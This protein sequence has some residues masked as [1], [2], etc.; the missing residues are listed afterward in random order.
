[1]ACD[2]DLTIDGALHDPLIAAVMRADRVDPKAFEI[3]LRGAKHRIADDERLPK[4]PMA[5]AARCRDM[6]SR[7][8]RTA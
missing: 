6:L 5:I 3:L 8:G 4:V 2:A 1:M 7:C